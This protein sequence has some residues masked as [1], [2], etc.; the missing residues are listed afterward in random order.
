MSRGTVLERHR[1]GVYA[2]AGALIVLSILQF[3]T[4]RG[5]SSDLGSK[6]GEFVVGV[7]DVFPPKSEAEAV[8]AGDAEMLFQ[9]SLASGLFFMLAC[10]LLPALGIWGASGMDGSTTRSTS[11]R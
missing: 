7:Q 4:V 6:L 5:Q 10:W 3:V 1:K 9:P 11:A 2:A 8:A